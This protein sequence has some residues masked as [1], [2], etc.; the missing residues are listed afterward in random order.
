M[1]QKA[2][3][4]IRGWISM[5]KGDVEGVAK[6]MRNTFNLCSLRECRRMVQE[7]QS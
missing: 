2:K 4:M 6:W 7:A 1:D 5:H 3:E